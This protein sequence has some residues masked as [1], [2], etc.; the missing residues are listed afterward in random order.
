MLALTE[1][2]GMYHLD[3]AHGTA[4]VGFVFAE[5]DG[6]CGVDLDACR[7]P[8]D[9]RLEPWAEDLVR[10]LDTFAEVSPSGRGVH[11]FARARLPGCVKRPGT[12]FS[13]APA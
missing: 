4:G 1:L 2:D 12:P 6:L 10:Q 8:Q 3:P 13:K 9:G 7:D 11:L 5:G